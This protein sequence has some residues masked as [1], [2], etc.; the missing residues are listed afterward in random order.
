MYKHILKSEQS[1]ELSAEENPVLT[2]H[3]ELCSIYG[4]VMSNV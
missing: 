2:Q 1:L 4:K 3:I